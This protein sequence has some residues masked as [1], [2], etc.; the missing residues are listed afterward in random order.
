[1]MRT[2]LQEAKKLIHENKVVD[3]AADIEMAITLCACSKL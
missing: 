2:L 1:M 3:F